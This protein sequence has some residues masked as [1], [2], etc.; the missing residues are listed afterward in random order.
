MTTSAELIEEVGITYRQL[1]YWIR[2]GYVDPKGDHN[3]GSGNRREFD[4]TEV[5]YVRTLALL[6]KTGMRI[7]SAANLALG[8]WATGTADLGPLTIY[9]KEH[10]AGTSLPAGQQSS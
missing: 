1:D 8:L 7:E 9:F 3:P 6:A 4:D 2:S 5:E 10:D